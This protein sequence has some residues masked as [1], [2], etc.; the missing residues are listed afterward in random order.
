MYY[1][2]ILTTTASILLLATACKKDNNNTP[3]PGQSKSRAI[4]FEV[5]GNYSGIINA[6]YITESGGGTNED[7]TALPWAK[8][9]NY[10]ASASGTTISLGGHAG[11]P[12]QT[13]TLKVYAGGTEVSSTSGTAKSDGI[14]VVV[15]PSYVF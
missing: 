2:T 1:K 3:T 11:Q 4:K 7:I 9:I 5:T 15:A 10:N 13:V 8:S 14:V 12:G 6:T